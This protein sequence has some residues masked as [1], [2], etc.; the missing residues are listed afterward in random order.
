MNLIDSSAWLEF[1]I[2]GP[3]AKHF[4]EPLSEINRVLV[5]TIVLYEVFKAVLIRRGENDALIVQAQMQLGEIV[6]LDTALALLA[7]KISAKHRIPMAD[8]IILATA[9]SRSATL[10]TQ[11]EDFKGIPGVKFFPK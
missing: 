4:A 5:P 10:W 1:F 9:Q 3:N 7:A 11:D 8:S 2:A 6:A